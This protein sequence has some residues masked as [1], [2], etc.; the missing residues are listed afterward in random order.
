MSIYVTGDTHGGEANG[1]KKFS[2]KNFPEGKSLTSEDY[3]II[4]GDFGLI[5]HNI[6][7]GEEIWW[8]KW[9]RNKP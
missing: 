3:V 4:C 7:T 6:P 5:W 9:L 8:T 2:S 1:F